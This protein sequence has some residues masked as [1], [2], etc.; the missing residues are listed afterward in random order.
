MDEYVGIIKLFAGNFAPKNFF[1]CNGQQLPINQ[2]AS[3]YSIVGTTYGGDGVT[4]FNLPDLRSRVPVG[5]G[6]GASPS[7][8]TTTNLGELAGE[9]FHTLLPTEM[10]SHNH[11][12][13]VSNSVATQANAT[14]GVSIATP[15]AGSGRSFAETLGFN[16]DAPSTQ[17]NTASGLP[18]GGNVPHN[19][20]QPYLGMSYIICWNGVYPVRP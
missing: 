17:L 4:T 9:T 5:G 12:I 1:Y 3:L 11:G 13:A 7:T 18:T 19:N 10:P 14:N 8:N 6:M 15:G 16:T 2:Y 20:M